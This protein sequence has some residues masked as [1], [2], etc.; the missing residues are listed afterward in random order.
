MSETDLQ[1]GTE[2]VAAPEPAER[3][4]TKREAMM[5]SVVAKRQQQMEAELAQGEIYDADAREAGLAYP[6]EDEPEPEERAAPVEP[7]A[8]RQNPVEPPLPP[9]QPAPV[10][11]QLRT[12]EVDG[13]QWAVTDD[14]YAQLARMGMFA[15]AA[16]HQYQQAAPEPQVAP[17]PAPVVDPEQVRRVVREIQYGGEDAA[18]T[19][20]AEYTQ[21]LLARVPPAQHVDQNA[22]VQRAVTAAQQA[23]ALEQHKQ[24]IKQEYADIFAHPQREFLAKVNVDTIRR[25]NAAT[26]QQ[27]SDIDIYREAGNMV[28][29][30]MGMQSRPGSDGVYSPAIQAAQVS[31]R[32]DVIERKRAAPRST[33]A[34]DRRAPA[35]E[36]PRQPSGSDIVDWMR[37]TR[38]QSPT[39]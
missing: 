9:R 28:R 34:I 32:S 23:A 31:P 7:A 24:I 5:A 12:V 19:A 30:A 22:I 11:P 37:K 1:T 15:N 18:A 26:G 14:Q 10:H 29:E 3:Q 35:P 36:A 20:L 17:A 2:A 39:R 25:R 27:Q 13:Q 16:L 8:A 33:S 21:S 4:P 6:L 38:G